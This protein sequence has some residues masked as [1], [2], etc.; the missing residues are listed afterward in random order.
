MK[1]LLLLSALALL[2]VGCAGTREKS[3]FV[4]LQISWQISDDIDSGTP[5]VSGCMI[6]MTNSLMAAPAVQEHADAGI[7]YIAVVT[8]GT[9]EDKPIV[10]FMGTCPPD[11]MLEGEVCSW[12]AEC[13][14]EGN[15]VDL[16]MGL[17]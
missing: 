14:S 2:F 12:K 4:P 3:N 6:K 9:K 7:S 16:K 15:I 8:T 11:A 13:D 17:E 5:Y 1:K 10:D